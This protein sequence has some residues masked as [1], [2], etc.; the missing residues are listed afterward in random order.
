M[1]VQGLDGSK[2]VQIAAG[3][4]QSALITRKYCV[5]FNIIYSDKCPSQE[6]SALVTGICTPGEEDLAVLQMFTVLGAFLYLCASSKLLLDGI[7][8]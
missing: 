4:E 5:S 6:H 1:K 8:C 7:T 3:A 2:V